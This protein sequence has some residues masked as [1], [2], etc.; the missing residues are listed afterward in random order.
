MT[1]GGMRMSKLKEWFQGPEDITKAEAVEDYAVGRVPS[2][3]RWPIPAIILV[4]LGNSTAMFWF[5]FGGDL[6]Y[7]VGWPNIIWPLLYM[8]VGA[9]FIGSC[10]MKIASKEGLSLSLLTRGL[11]FGYMGSAVTSLIYAV[12][13]IF[14]FLFEGTIVSHAIA[15][16]AGIQINSFAGVAIFATIGLITIWFVWK[17]MSSMQFLQT[18][19]VP[20]FLVLFLFGLYE[21]STHYQIIGPASW[22]PKA[23]VTA[24]SI[25]TVMNMANGQLVFQGLMATDY[26]RFAKPSISYKGTATIMIGMLVPAI[27]VILFGAMLAYTLIPHLDKANAYSLASD[28]GFAFPFVMGIIGMVFAVITQIRINVMNLYSGSLALSNTMDMAFNFRPGRQWWMLLVWL[29]GVIFYAFNVLQYTDTFLAITG[30]L[31]NTWVFII[32]ADY[33]ICRKVM[34][35]AP[36]D[37]V[38]FRKEYLRSWN[39]SGIFALLIAV[40]IGSLG[41]FG[42]YPI[43][44]ASF[45]SMIIGPILH[46]FFTVATKGKYYFSKF[47]TDVDTSWNPSNSYEGPQPNESVI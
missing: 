45:L 18:W 21:L 19:G 31:T 23:G 42:V 16:F 17:G 43:Y 26:G 37:F 20:I 34:N 13:Y 28:P 47:P 29:L 30:I 9:T 8:L 4:L 3:Y 1:K 7:L 40:I 36:S 35:L 41:V 12:N 32:L 27:L 15:N 25:W 33:Y 22:M 44:Y 24:V 10:T 11:G 6:T 38:E 5:S 46:I 14:Y 2:R 39:P